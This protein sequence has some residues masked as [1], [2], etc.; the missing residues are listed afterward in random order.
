LNDI[1]YDIDL[2]SQICSCV[3]GI[4]GKICK[5]LIACSLLLGIDLVDLT[6][7]NAESRRKLD[8]TAHGKSQDLSFY[9][10]EVNGNE[11]QATGG[12]ESQEQQGREEEYREKINGEEE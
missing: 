11:N 2:Q 7:H 9:Q 1:W 5:H 3:E 8:V 10:W 12:G 6:P 4:V